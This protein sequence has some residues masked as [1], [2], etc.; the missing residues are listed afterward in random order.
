MATRKVGVYR[1]YHGPVPKDSDGNPLP[2]RL[3]PKK[4]PF[5]WCVRWFGDDGKRYSRSFGSRKE[6]EYFAHQKQAEVH[7]G[8]LDE[9]PEISLQDFSKEHKELVRGQFAHSTLALY[10]KSTAALAE[11]V[12]W[13]RPLSSISMRDI[14]KFISVRLRSGRAASTVNVDLRVLRRSFNL[15]IARGY[16]RPG[17]NP[18]DQIRELKVCP[19]QPRYLQ[20]GDFRKVL[21]LT[22]DPLARAFYVTV[23]TTALRLGEAVNL[24]WDNL[25]F[26]SGTVHIA[27]KE[28]C[29]YVQAWT[30]KDQE[31]RAVPLCEQAVTLLTEW[32]ALSPSDCP[33]VF[34]NQ[35]RWDYYRQ[36]VESGWW[37]PHM[38]LVQ[39]VTRRFQRLC[40]KA[41]VGS[42]TIHDMRRSCI[43]NWAKQLPIHVVRQ[44][45]GHSKL[46]TTQRYYLSVHA[47]D[48]D[49]ARVAQGGLLGQILEP[50][51]LTQK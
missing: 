28:R 48:L 8:I 3:W 32:R 18:C 47:E 29:G 36:R 34:M 16:L 30:P 46:T 26:D 21:S 12:G 20:P 13:R 37:Q 40:L 24:T 17:Q 2:R 41:K 45:A 4:R 38:N 10:R 39:N 15:A 25:D 31:M 42:Y 6:A 9:P 7:R 1:K 27:R 19:K 5:S 50:K 43:T 44:L 33:Y 51:T 11:V 22:N 49:R 35:Q 14:E 23:Y